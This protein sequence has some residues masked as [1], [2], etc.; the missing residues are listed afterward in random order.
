MGSIS[1]EEWDSTRN[2]WVR[3]MGRKWTREE[4][5]RSARVWQSSSGEN[6]DNQLHDCVNNHTAFGLSLL[7]CLL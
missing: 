7:I 6:M 4:R 5:L 1:F 3:I 2:S